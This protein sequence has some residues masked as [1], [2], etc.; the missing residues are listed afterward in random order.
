M[1]VMSHYTCLWI[2]NMFC[3]TKRTIMKLTRIIGPCPSPIPQSFLALPCTCVKIWQ[4]W[5]H[6]PPFLLNTICWQ[7]IL[8]HN[9]DLAVFLKLT[10]VLKE[11]LIFT[12]Y[13]QTS[14]SVPYTPLS[15][16]CCSSI[17]QTEEGNEPERGPAKLCASLNEMKHCSELYSK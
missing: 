11:L 9:K 14:L 3:C 5:Y 13:P 2:L 12:C 17:H 7:Y 16:P 10:L 15:Q 1:P 6:F 4:Y 8:F